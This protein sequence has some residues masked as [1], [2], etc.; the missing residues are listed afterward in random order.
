MTETGNSLL[1]PPITQHHTPVKT[2]GRAR[3]AVRGL[4]PLADA[5]RVVIEQQRTRGERALHRV[6]FLATRRRHAAM[7][8]V[9]VRRCGPPLALV[10]DRDDSIKFAGVRAPQEQFEQGEKNVSDTFPRHTSSVSTVAGS[11][12]NL[13]TENES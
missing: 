2:S 13:F 8:F 9:N 10:S 3:Q 7:R 4:R 12:T 11:S 1:P 5:G 6:L